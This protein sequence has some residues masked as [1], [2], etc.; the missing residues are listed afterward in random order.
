M[1]TVGHRAT[2]CLLI[3]T[4]YAELPSTNTQNIMS[5]NHNYN[6]RIYLFHVHLHCVFRHS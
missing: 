4:R 1:I 2:F 6:I 5:N 3:V